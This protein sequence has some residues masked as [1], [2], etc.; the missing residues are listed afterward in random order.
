MRNGG[1]VGIAAVAGCRGEAS[2]YWWDWAIAI[3]GIYWGL[4]ET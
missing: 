2:W 3:R 1:L 4:V